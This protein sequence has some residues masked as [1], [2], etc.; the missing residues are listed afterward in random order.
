MYGV[1]PNM[2]HRSLVIKALREGIGGTILSS[3]G[4]LEPSYPPFVKGELPALCSGQKSAQYIF[5]LGPGLASQA[6]IGLR[7]QCSQE[8][9][10]EQRPGALRKLGRMELERGHGYC[11]IR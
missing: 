11:S 5:P 2:S 1:S 9:M 6:T 4:N 10:D 7:A 3:L 8:G